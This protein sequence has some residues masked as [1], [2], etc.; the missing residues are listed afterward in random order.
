[1]KQNLR[2][3]ILFVS[4]IGFSACSSVMEQSEVYAMPATPELSVTGGKA[5]VE[6][7]QQNVLPLTKGYRTIS[8]YEGALEL[9]IPDHFTEMSTEMKRF[10]Y[11][12]GN[13]PGLVYT[14]KAA[15][16]NVALSYTSTVIKEGDLLVLKVTYGEQ[17]SQGVEGFQSRMERIN[18]S[19][20][21]VFE[22]MSQAIDTKVYNQM[23]FTE[24]NGRLLMGTFN[25]TQALKEEWQSK[26]KVI[27]SSI[28]KL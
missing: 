19:D 17:L 18:G 27:L 28:R 22:F 14:D 9:S 13:S 4:I 3:P 5:A 6:S 21:V 25:C 8:L 20:F 10:K 15:A 16:V 23:F 24:L 1:M 2:L 7:M 12:R 11:P 26:G